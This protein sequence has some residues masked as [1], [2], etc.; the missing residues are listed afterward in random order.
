M[1]LIT[2]SYRSLTDAQ[3]LATSPEGTKLDEVINN[4]KNNKLYLLIR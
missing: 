1:L 3:L 2:V 4:N